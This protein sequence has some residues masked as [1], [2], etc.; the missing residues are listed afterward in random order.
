MAKQISIVDAE[1][2]QVEILRN[3]DGTL[4]IDLHRLVG[5]GRIPFGA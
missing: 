5:L 2:V 3:P 1:I 4:Q